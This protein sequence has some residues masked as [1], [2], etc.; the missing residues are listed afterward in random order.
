[1]GATVASVLVD[2]GVFEFAHNGSDFSSEQFQSLC[3]FGYSNKRSLRTI[4]FRGIG[5]KST[6]SLGDTVEVQTPTL[7]VTFDAQRFTVPRWN[8]T[9]SSQSGTLIRVKAAGEHELKAS[10]ESLLPWSSNPVSLLFFAN[11][12]SLTVNGKQLVC[13]ERGAGPV[14]GSRQVSL[15]QG[16]LHDI[17]LFR[18]GPL[19]LPLDAQEEVRRERRSTDSS[20]MPPVFVDLV[21]GLSEQRLF[22]VLPTALTTRL[23][24]S[25]NA[26][27][28]LDPARNF[29]KDLSASPTNRFLLEQVGVFAAA[30]MIEWLANSALTLEER[31][32]AYSLLPART[33]ILKGDLAS[34]VYATVDSALRQALQGKAT[35]LTSGGEV[36]LPG[37]TVS[38]DA[39]IHSVWSD[40][41]LIQVLSCRGKTLL[42]PVVSAS[43]ALRLHSL[44]WTSVLDRQGV[45]IRL[46]CD[47][48]PRPQSSQQLVRLWRY[49]ASAGPAANDPDLQSLYLLPCVRQEKLVRATDVVRVG[50][51]RRSF[52]PGAWTFVINDLLRLDEAWL[53]PI[54]DDKGDDIA[55]T[56]EKERLLARRFLSSVGLADGTSVA[57]LLSA[58]ALQLDQQRDS[59]EG[60]WIRLARVV[61]TIDV[62]APKELKFLTKSGKLVRAD[63]DVLLDLASLD[64]LLSPVDRDARVISPSYLTQDDDCSAEKWNL[65]MQSPRSRLRTLPSFVPGAKAADARQWNR[66]DAKSFVKK[67]RGIFPESL[68][69]ATDKFELTDFDFPPNLVAYWKKLEH[70]QADVWAKVANLVL[71]DPSMRWRD[72]LHCSLY[73][74]RGQNRR[75]VA[76]KMPASWVVHLKG[77]P[78]L[79]GNDGK[80]HTPAEL[81]LRT[82]DNEAFLSGNTEVFVATE[83][84]T[85][86]NRP[87]LMAM[88]VMDKPAQMEPALERI[89]ALSQIGS[90]API[91]EIAKWYNYLD[92]ILTRRRPEDL[93]KLTERLRTEALVFTST[94]NWVSAGGVYQ[95]QGAIE[96]GGLQII[97][98]ELSRLAL[99]DLIKVPRQPSVDLILGEFKKW[100]SLKKL[101]GAELELFRA[102]STKIPEK[103]WDECG[104]WVNLENKW[105]QT[106]KLTSVLLKD[107]QVD[108]RELSPPIKSSTADARQ[109]AKAGA[110]FEA[111]NSL[112]DLSGQIQL[113]IVK[114]EPSAGSRP[115][116]EW[117]IEVGKWFARVIFPNDANRQRVFR[118]QGV[119]MYRTRAVEFKYLSMAPFLDGVQIGLPSPQTAFWDGETL[120]IKAGLKTQVFDAVV[121]A[122]AE[123]LEQSDLAE[124]ILRSCYQRDAAFVKE[125]L[126]GQPHRCEQSVPLDAEPAF[127]TVPSSPSASL[128]VDTKPSPVV[129][130][131]PVPVVKVLATSQDISRQ[132]VIVA[133]DGYVGG[134]LTLA[135]T[136]VGSYQVEPTCELPE[137]VASAVT[138]VANASTPVEVPSAGASVTLLVTSDEP[139]TVDIEGA[140]S[141]PSAKAPPELKSTPQLAASTEE[142]KEPTLRLKAVPLPIASDTVPPSPTAL[143]APGRESLVKF[144]HAIDSPPE[145]TSLPVDDSGILDP[146]FGSPPEIVVPRVARLGLQPE[147]VS[148]PASST[149]EAPAERPAHSDDAFQPTWPGPNKELS[150][151]STS[152]GAGLAKFDPPPAGVLE[153]FAR[154]RN[155]TWSSAIACFQSP[156]G[157]QIRRGESILN[158]ELLEGQTVVRRFV[159]TEECLQKA[160]LVVAAEVWEAIKANPARSAILARFT[161]HR[162]QLLTGE[163]LLQRAKGGSLTV[164]PSQYRVRVTV[165]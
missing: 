131:Q 97:H 54:L 7:S 20:E 71:A 137:S 68:H 77:R 26:P 78:S 30:W 57:S 49:V 44:G 40:E 106:C 36:V 22:T 11:V 9:S 43:A 119:R 12:K 72:S 126:N 63:H 120:H 10:S 21:L 152:A 85:P 52:T 13:E 66:D 155:C 96:I 99:W 100:P 76:D 128:F 29:I 110:Q 136:P 156:A 107:L 87:L 125:Y 150:N 88:G 102:V 75:L 58:K 103:I 61:A 90:E 42:A 45:L 141:A 89:A 144:Y 92:S 132:P 56:R 146:H 8:D 135:T 80:P 83:L 138:V 82:P 154:A 130:I 6:F 143:A 1:V 160:G 65:W 53:A 48:P 55:G 69:Y 159:V 18:S 116:V 129:P 133:A 164:F 38:V 16:G 14:R 4:G 79:F 62:D 127:Q 28:I 23:P 35:V 73:Q 163:T 17:I 39:D 84:D 139:P 37:S 3:N 161:D 81:L 147:R 115:P 108:V 117:L 2:D 118:E 109:L 124:R 153:A 123:P 25:I 111:L 93:N 112:I 64:A 91:S 59:E 122:L 33:E 142:V 151:A 165:G 104:H 121:A 145:P 24:F 74:C 98:P 157:T 34:A 5:F 86:A 113:R 140:V 162:P 46:S 67:R 47:A 51:G 95:R 15:S 114:N 134:I 105:Q 32:R 70:A 148:F 94:K 41:S 50:I 19:M 60:D 31:A 149:H 158:W 27:F 101:D